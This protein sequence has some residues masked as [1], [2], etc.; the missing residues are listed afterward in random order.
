MTRIVRKMICSSQVYLGDT[1]RIRK[2]NTKIPRNKDFNACVTSQA[3]YLYKYMVT[4]RIQKVDKE[5]YSRD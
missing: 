3:E 2:Y 5:G 4:S 1:K